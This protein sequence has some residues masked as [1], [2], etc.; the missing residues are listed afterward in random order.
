MYRYN[1]RPSGRLYHGETRAGATFVL[2]R[3]DGASF[4]LDLDLQWNSMYMYGVQYMY[5][6]THNNQYTCTPCHLRTRLRSMYRCM[7]AWKII[8]CV[9]LRSAACDRQ[10]FQHGVQGSVWVWPPFRRIHAAREERALAGVRAVWRRTPWHVP[11]VYA[12][13]PRRWEGVLWTDALNAPWWSP[14]R[15]MFGLSM[16]ALRQP[17]P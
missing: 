1:T 4:V 5:S 13:Q 7:V 14:L 3:R 12:S 17:S 10:P 6:T 11:R 16:M 8:G 2:T 15:R 9:R